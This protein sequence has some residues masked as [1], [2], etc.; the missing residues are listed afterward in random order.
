MIRYLGSL[1]TAQ[2]V[3]TAAASLSA[4]VLELQAQVTA[5]FEA[6]ATVN[7]GGLAGYVTL[8]GSI[9]GALEAAIAAGVTPPTIS[10]QASGIFELQVKLEAL[11]A[12]QNLMTAGG[13]HALA[14]RGR[15]DDF[16]SELGSAVAGLPG[17]QPS[18]GADAIAL[19]ATTPAAIEALRAVFAQ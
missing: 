8:A 19:L 18:D 5:L 13:I 3:P 14:Y 4:A 1:S 6:S 15:A 2:L 10:F 16:A 12:L 11:L 7:P 17:V 9:I